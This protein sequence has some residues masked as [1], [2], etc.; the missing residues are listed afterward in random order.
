M[1]KMLIEKL[2]KREKKVNKEIIVE[3]TANNVDRE[4]VDALQ[5]MMAM[6]M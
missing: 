4:A 3:E 1:I 5:F 2:N 6:G